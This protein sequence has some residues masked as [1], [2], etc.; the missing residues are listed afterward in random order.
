MFRLI[1]ILPSTYYLLVSLANLELAIRW[2]FIVF[3]LNLWAEITCEVLICKCNKYIY[4]QKLYICECE[5]WLYAY[6]RHCVCLLDYECIRSTLRILIDYTCVRSYLRILVMFV[7]SIESIRSRLRILG[8]HEITGGAT[9]QWDV[10]VGWE[11]WNFV[12]MGRIL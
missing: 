6:G 11:M 7:F 4:M 8:T 1:E 9:L 10:W 2:V 5:L 3:S 12:I